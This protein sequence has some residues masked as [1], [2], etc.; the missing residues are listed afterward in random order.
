MPEILKAAAD[1]NFYSILSRWGPVL[2]QVALIFFFSH[3][4]PASLILQAFP[5]S[6]VIGHLGGYGLL[7]LLLYRAI[8]GGCGVWNVRAAWMVLA[9]AVFYGITDEL[10]QSFVP[11]RHPSAADIVVDGVGAALA[12]GAIWVYAARIRRAGSSRAAP[13]QGSVR[14][15]GG[16]R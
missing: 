3:Q 14:V 8:K 15:E 4:P 6:S 7:A 5:L 1:K 2:L 10:H 13:E 12:L 16:E 9:L 11:G